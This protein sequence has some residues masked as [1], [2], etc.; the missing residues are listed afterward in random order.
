MGGI[1]ILE[2]GSPGPDQCDDVGARRHEDWVC[3]AD[4]S[5]SGGEIELLAHPE[6][7]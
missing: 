7:D 3:S 2:A 6:R 5:G 1:S 4:P